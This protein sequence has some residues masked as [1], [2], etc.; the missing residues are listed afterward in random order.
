MAL[1][2]RDDEV[3]VLAKQVQA[4]I[5]APSK[6]EAVRIALEHE[7]R[8]AR[9]AEPLE[10]RIKRLQDAVKAMGPDDPDLDMKEFMDELSGGI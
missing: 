6:T 10:V 5:K 2:I 1:Y 4:A 3:D 7:L 9:Q 8:R